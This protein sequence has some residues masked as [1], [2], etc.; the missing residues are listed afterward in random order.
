MTVNL[1]PE[2]D[3]ENKMITVLMIDHEDA[4]V[5]VK[6]SGGTQ[7]MT[8]GYY[9]DYCEVVSNGSTRLNIGSE[10]TSGGGGRG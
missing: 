10:E 3:Y 9:G 1:P 2:S 4:E 5:H 7:F 8:F 6:D